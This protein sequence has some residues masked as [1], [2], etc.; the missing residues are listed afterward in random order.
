MEVS[1]HDV[2]DQC[3]WGMVR[4]HQRDGRLSIGYIWT[5]WNDGVTRDSWYSFLRSLLA[6][7]DAGAILYQLSHEAA[8]LGAGQFV[9]IVFFSVKGLMNEIYVYIEER[10]I[11]EKIEVILA[12]AEV[13][14]SIPV[15]ATGTFRWF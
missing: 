3:V 1:G 8:Q 6:L 10:V 14:S 11:D 9:G 2:F 5:L 7:C 15:E 13:V 12:L 4:Q